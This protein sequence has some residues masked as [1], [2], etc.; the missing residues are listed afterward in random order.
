M[1]EK[2]AAG[3]IPDRKFENRRLRKAIEKGEQKRKEWEKAPTKKI[4]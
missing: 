4:A 2:D 1:I 3:A